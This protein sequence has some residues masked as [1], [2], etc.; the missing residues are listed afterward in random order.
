MATFLSA[1]KS[2]Y[3][4]IY[5]KLNTNRGA[6]GVPSVG[7]T[8]NPNRVELH[9]WE[10]G[11]PM[12]KENG[13]RQ[14]SLTLESMCDTSLPDAF[15][16]AEKSIGMILESNGIVTTGFNI[17]GTIVQNISQTTEL[18][19]SANTIFKVLVTFR[20]YVQVEENI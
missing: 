18:S 13:V 9:S 17:I 5:G 2:V 10:E 1:L 7:M 15:Q 19:D 11:E 20:V 14:I 3:K 12:D 6:I 16:W 4:G 8:A